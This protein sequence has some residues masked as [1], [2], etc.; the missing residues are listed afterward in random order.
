MNKLKRTVASIVV[1]AFTLLF[2]LS[3]TIPLEAAA[4]STGYSITSVDHY[5]QVLYTGNVMVIDTIH[6][7][8]SVSDGFQIGLPLQ[9]S[10]IVLKALAYDGRYSYPV[11]LGVPLGNHSGFYGAQVSFNGHSPSTFTVVFVLNNDLLSDNG[12]GTYTLI[13]PAY[14]SFTQN[15]DNCHVI[16][17]FPTAPQKLSITKNDGDISDSSYAQTNLPAYTFSVAKATAKLSAGSIEPSQVTNLNRE[18]TID[19]TGKVTS[20]DTYKITNNSPSSPLSSFL[21]NVSPQASNV[22]VEDQFGASLTTYQSTVGGVMTVNTTLSSFVSNRQTATLKATYN[23]PGATLQGGKYV[24]N[25]FELFPKFQYVVD[26]A[27]LSFTSPEGSTIETPQVSTLAESSTLTRDTFQDTLTV[28]G[29]S[30]SFADYLAPQP[31]TIELSYSYSPVW[32]SFRPT[33]WAAGA[34]AVACLGALVYRKVR[35]EE[36]TYRTRVEKLTNRIQPEHE[37]HLQEI[38]TGQPITTDII[39]DFLAAYDDKNQLRIELRALERNA[40]KGKIPRRQYKVQ[41]QAIETRMDSL[42]RSVERTKAV[43]RGSAGVYPDLA[44]QLDLAEEDLAL[45]AE[46]IR[47]LEWRYGRGEVSLETYKKTIV[48]YQK[49]HA[50][51]EAAIN[52]ILL[53]LREKI[54]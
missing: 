39:R 48:D 25:D 36:E 41:K 23:L 33:F 13:Y 5:V 19:P 47:N 40:Q 7:T 26:Q 8:G 31:D 14:P 1:A 51:A 45:A 37:K 28:S 11:N 12:N 49:V 21:L 24:L 53:R 6:L 42:N 35:P 4:Q 52:G 38:K 29:K 46:N 9:Y 15:V 18:I 3:A 22:V 2:A 30:V 20:T 32:V 50:K 34:A 27:V 54:R 10:A 17:D 43:F 44:K 16:L